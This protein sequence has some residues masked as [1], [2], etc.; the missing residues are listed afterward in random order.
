[1]ATYKKRSFKKN[2]ST[3]THKGNDQGSSTAN[4]FNTLDQSSSSTQ[5]FFEK[6][7]KIIYTAVGLV[8]FLTL[9]YLF[10]S[11]NILAP[12]QKEAK[13]KMYFAQKKFDEAVLLNNDSIFN[14]VLNGDGTNLGM[15]NII[16]EYS[17][18]DASNLAYYYAGISYFKKNDYQNS[19]RYLQ[20]FD[21]K[22]DILLGSNQ[23]GNI[24]DAFSNLYQ[25]EDAYKYYVLASKNENNFTTPLYLFKAAQIAIELN[26]FTDAEDF[27]RKIKTKYPKSNEAKNID[28][29]I[30]MA[31]ALNK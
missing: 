6:N 1:M 24:A 28:A 21:P 27:F 2:S 14:V 4:V 30:S 11:T 7:Q 16:D 19:I 8:V 26:K 20:D 9:G 31:K 17:G 13:N 22:S 12:K 18:T 25:Y 5:L 23:D 15:L 29:F 3:Y 10:Y